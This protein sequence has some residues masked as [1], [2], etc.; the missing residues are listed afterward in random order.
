VT[1]FALNE[2]GNLPF[3]QT[4]N[5]LLLDV[6]IGAG[7]LCFIVAAAQHSQLGAPFETRFAR[8]L[9]S[10][11]YSLYLLHFPILAIGDALLLDAHV[12]PLAHLSALLFLGVPI[13]LG[14]SWLLYRWVERP[15]MR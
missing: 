2:A 4:A 14:A 5:M 7:T 6:L 3:G 10:F 15:S 12:S 11:S 1:G 8:T 13:A 9:G